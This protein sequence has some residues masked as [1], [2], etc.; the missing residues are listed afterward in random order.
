MLGTYATQ[1][2]QKIDLLVEKSMRHEIIDEI[3]ALQLSSSKEVFDKALPLFVKKW[4]QKKQTEFVA[5]M[6][7][8]WFT[9]HQY[10]KEGVAHHTPSTNNALESFNLVIKK[11]KNFVNDYHF[12]DFLN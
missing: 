2:Y 8:Q 5:Y 6:K 10:W 3:D 4:L 11:K 9:T 1:Y 12:L 7:L